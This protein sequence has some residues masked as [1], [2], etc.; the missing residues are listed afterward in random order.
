[1][2]RKVIKYDNKISVTIPILLFLLFGYSITVY[3]QEKTPNIQIIKYHGIHPDDP[4]GRDGLTNPE[5]GF[6]LES[7]IGQAPGSNIW[8]QGAYLKERVGK[9]FSDDW[10]LMNVRRYRAYG[11]TLHQAYCYLTDFID[12][13]I[14]DEK[15][16]YLQHSLDRMRQAGQKIL[17]RFAYEKNST[18]KSGSTG[19]RI[20]QHLEQLAPLIKKNKDIIY[21]LQAGMVGAWGE[22]HSSANYIEEDHAMLAKI[23]AKELEI[24]PKERMIQLRIMPKYK[25]WVLNKPILDNSTKLTAENAFSGTPVARL[26]FANDGTLANISDGGS[27]PESPFYANPANPAF[28]RVTMESPYMAVDGELYWSDQGGQIDGLRAA[29]RFRLHHYGSLSLT[30]SYSGYEGKRY[31]IDHWM[32]TPVSAGKLQ[33]E[34]LPISDS[35]FNDYAGRSVERT[36]FEYIRDHLGYRIELQQAVF[37]KSIDN[38]QKL[39]VKV[40]LINRGFSTLINPRP[41]YLVLIN[42]SGELILK[43]KTDANPQTWQPFNPGDLEYKPLI[44]NISDNISVENLEIGEYMVGLWMPDTDGNIQ[45]DSRYAART[46]NRDTPWWTTADGK[47]GVNILGSIKISEK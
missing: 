46:A 19:K 36:F 24:L 17:L 41:V 34:K 8:G 4:G 20:L 5:R 2:M 27:W 25:S 1:M 37:P 10:F 22:W 39:N 13:P 43:Q 47:Y 9:G 6:R 42:T 35:Y 32:E 12:K 26:G 29:K 14:S 28:D 38:D 11:V 40:D 44:H 7:Y 21:V 33:E 18:R 15:L 45:L 16:G 30:H 31:S 23:V 3:S